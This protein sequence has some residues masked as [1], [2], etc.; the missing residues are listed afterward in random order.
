MYRKEVTGALQS[1]ARN[2]NTEGDWDRFVQLL[3]DTPPVYLRDLLD[4]V[5][6][7]SVPIDQVDGVR[8]VVSTT[9]RGAA[10]SHGALHSTAHRAIAAAFNELGSRSNSGEGG[11]DARRNPDGP[12]AADRNRTRQVASGRFGVDAAYL[13][14]ADELEIKIGQGAK[15]GEGG[16]LPA[17]KV[18]AEIAAIRKTAVGVDLISPPPHHDIYSIED[19]AQLVRNLRAANPEALIGVKVPAVTNLGTIAVGVAK[20]GADVITISGFEGGT[21]AASSGS[22]LHA[23][24]PLE[25][26]LTD[27]HQ[28]LV[29]AGI[30]SSVRLR[31]DGG[32]KRGMDVAKIMALG[33]DE[34]GFGTAL[35]VAENCVFCRGC[36]HGRCPVGLA[37]Q[38]EVRQDKLF[39]SKNR[40][41]I[42][43][44]TAMSQRYNE[45]KAGVRRYLECLAQ[46]LRSI[47]AELGLTHPSQLTGRVDLL[48]VKPTEHARWARLEL[49]EL[50]LDVSA[51]AQAPK[52]PHPELASINREV[53][54]AAT[55]VLGGQALEVVIPLEL[56]PC[57]Q[58]VGATLAGQIARDGG[59]REHA[60]V[61]LHARGAAGQAFG[62]A[63]T[64]GMSFVLEGYANDCVGE[65]MGGDAEITVVPP[66][67]FDGPDTAHL[68]GNAVA[69]GATGG[70]LFVAGG[71]GQRFGVRNSGAVLVAERAGKYAF[72]YMTGG[73]G[74]VLG[75][76]AGVIGSGMTGGELFLLG[77]GARAILHSDAVAV[78]VSS[79]DLERLKLIVVAFAERTQSAVAAG[80]LASWPQARRRF[81]RVRPRLLVERTEAAAK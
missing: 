7:Q 67:E 14:G 36:N 49:N 3:E 28:Y 58:A 56:T 60:R 55:P 13:V 75:P 74:I 38:D 5:P 78:S 59:L 62:F 26:G 81:V 18:T 24:L 35:M 31:A 10:M 22:I 40:E 19:L 79:A 42:G 64:S 33:A 27:A 48:R 53:L 46:D 41:H 77:K 20:A 50:L 6:Q 39:M 70:E 8:E 51:H 43:P 25:L 29:T 61:H 30:R 63:A 68:A 73:I 80:L 37:T 44:G 9:L 76:C 21:G 16:H 72:E 32:I 71:V 12:W 65:V 23:G 57:D 54:R 1:V 15:P 34:V 52:R 17:N 4:F 69:Y 45:A 2:G 47:L 11:E 66:A